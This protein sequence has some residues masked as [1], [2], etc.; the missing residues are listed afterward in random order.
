MEFLGKNM[1]K[2][3]AD[4]SDSIEAPEKMM[5][6]SLQFYDH[7]HALHKAMIN[8]IP[9]LI[10]YKDVNGIY[11][12]CNAAFE[13]FAGIREQDIIG[14]VD[15]DLFPDNEVERF[16]KMDIETIKTKVARKYEES[17]TCPNGKE[18]ILET[19]KT[20]YFDAQG[21]VIGLLGVSRDVTERKEE[22]K[23]ILYLSYHDDLTGLFNRTYF[24]K[25]IA[26]LDNAEH[27]PFSIIVGDINGM[28]LINDVYG[29]VQGDTLIQNTAEILSRCGRAG[30]VVTR[31]GGDEFSI[32][33][34]NTDG[35][36]AE[37]LI[38]EMKIRFKNLAQNIQPAFVDISFGCATKR[39]ESES[40]KAT[41]TLAED[42]MYRGKL[43][44]RQSQHSHILATI[45]TLMLEKSYETECHTERLA[46]SS[47]ELGQALGLS[48]DKMNELELTA[49][50]HD[51]GKMS[52]DQS[53][54][55]KTE[56]LSEADWKEIKKHPEI[57]CRILSSFPELSHVATYVLYH[58]EHWDGS[59]YPFG[60]SGE[61]IPL[62]S[63]IIAVTDA[64][65]AM[66]QDRAYRKAL[67]LAATRKEILKNAGTQFDPNV[68]KTFVNLV[69]SRLQEET[70]ASH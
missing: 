55:T 4:K 17:V 1:K 50:L 58:H 70:E 64:Y 29:H 23:R 67:S 52:I 49:L 44:T 68:A 65:D 62:I 9:D 25:A 37:R 48:E 42:Q 47:K 51:I 63:R 46:V 27:L 30:D 33:L 24:F 32:L 26:E 15:A 39:K 36:D 12:G 53:I 56:R 18:M 11:W 59:G 19:I 14:H 31:T 60:L 54:L 20:P 2:L 22:E 66:T 35:N 5:G 13:V 41:M 6:A 40:F 69:L 43:L 28:K 7:N 61:E 38:K 45:K 57:G 34:P 10:F 16:L 8:C 3:S 21:N